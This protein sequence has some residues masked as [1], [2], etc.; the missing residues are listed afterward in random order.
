MLCSQFHLSR[1]ELWG[2]TVKLLPCRNWHCEHC[3][4]SR[5]R[6][7]RAIAASGIPTICLTLTVNT[8]T[9]SNP[10]ERYQALHRAW[11]LLVK[12]TLR[13]FAKPPNERWIIR[14]DEDCEYQQIQDY[15]YTRTV[16]AKAIK[17]L[18]YMAF[19]EETE[20]GEPHLHILLR[21]KYIPQRWIS[22]QMA[23]II[24]SPV[25]WIE[26]VKG[27]KAAVAYVT[28]YVTK[29]PAQF[30]KS[31]RYWCSKFYQL[32]KRA[33]P[34]TPVFSRAT[35]QL[36]HQPFEE[37]VRE[38]VTKGLCVIP[39]LNKELEVRKLRDLQDSTGT[40]T[41]GVGEAE[42]VSAYLWLGS[43]RNRCAI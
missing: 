42:L 21:T 7:L 2:R 28:K 29:A 38:I 6:Q 36:I 19:P 18:H 37:F 27:A 9:A 5:L 33:K 20:N 34:D 24:N 31:R 16:A 14:S 4:P 3:Q 12:R 39:R 15:Y 10:V 26:K 25:V 8:A 35:A 32:K 30:G 13:E 41:K 40:Y 17:R 22:Q 23:D 11:K 1:Q 43:W